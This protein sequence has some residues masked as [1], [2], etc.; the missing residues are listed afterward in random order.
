MKE[1]QVKKSYVPQG[2]PG[3]ASVKKLTANADVRDVGSVPGLGGS[4]PWRRAWQPTPVFF[5]G[6]SHG[7]RSL[8]GYSPQG[9][10]ES[11]TTE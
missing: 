6:E 4:I 10:K 5:P 7:Q 9:R 1:T 2:L 3:G 11:D 8:A